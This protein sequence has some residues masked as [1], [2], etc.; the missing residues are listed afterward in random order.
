MPH[1]FKFYVHFNNTKI[2]AEQKAYFWPL[3]KIH[4]TGYVFDC[5]SNLDL[6]SNSQLFDNL[7][8]IISVYCQ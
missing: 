7:K 3:V 8:Y 2:V 4:S 6:F 5:F 1:G